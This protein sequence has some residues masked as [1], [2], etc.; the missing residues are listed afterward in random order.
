MPKNLKPFE[1][2]SFAEIFSTGTPPDDTSERVIDIPL[3][4]LHDFKDHPFQI[5]MDKDMLELIESVKDH[6]V[7]MPGIAR[8]RDAGGYE[9]VAGHR[10]KYCCQEASIVTM[11]I[12]VREMD[13]DT[14][15][16]LMV[17]SNVQRE[18]IYPSDRA[19][20]LKMLMEA[21]NRQGQRNDL[22][23]SEVQKELHGNW[24][25]NEAISKTGLKKSKIYDFISLTKLIPALLQMVDDRKLAITVA[26][27]LSFL[28]EHEQ[29][30]LFTWMDAHKKKPTL[31]QA[32]TL[33]EKSKAGALDVNELDELLH[34]E[35][36]LPKKL[37]L[38]IKKMVSPF[39]PGTSLQTM[40]NEI[41]QLLAQRRI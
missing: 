37:E 13:D 21:L 41:Y 19:R 5:R 10:R 23:S 1:I 36:I 38:P 39:P 2:S 22:T 8:S 3:E 29:V 4:E 35:P 7:L 25:I 31:M 27:A 17:Q 33:K 12:I 15:T 18:S 28:K 16:I 24:S 14:A 26:V 11:P 34:T 20:A 6:G 9:V 40:Q 30:V 32:T